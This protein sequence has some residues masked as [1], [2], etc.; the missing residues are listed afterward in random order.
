MAKLSQGGWTSFLI[1][2]HNQA[3]V[4]ARLEA[5]SKN[6]QPV[7]YMGNYPFPQRTPKEELLTEGQIANR[8][9]DVQLY[10]N[11]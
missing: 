10:R 11:P 8:F 4:T 3:G 1:K 5:Q 9:L 6:A 7:F 2:V